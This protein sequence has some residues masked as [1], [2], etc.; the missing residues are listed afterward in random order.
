MKLAAVGLAL[1]S[2][3]SISWALQE[4]SRARRRDAIATEA[5][6]IARAANADLEAFSKEV[7]AIV[8]SSVRNVSVTPLR[9]LV[10]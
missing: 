6:G 5:L 7:D 9:A 3:L 4:R 2:A 10:G 1:V 8:A